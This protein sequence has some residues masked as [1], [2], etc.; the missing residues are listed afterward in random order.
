[1]KLT[2]AGLALV[3]AATS[4][5]ALA[6][7]QAPANAANAAAP[8]VKPSA[9]ASKA[10][11]DLQ[12]AVNA[13]DATSIPAKV[14]AANAVA[15]T[16]E[17]RYLIGELQLSGAVH[18]NDLA[19]ASQ[20]IDEIA[21]S[22][23]LPAPQVAKLYDAIGGS[24]YKAKQY[25]QAVAAYQHEIALDPQATDPQLM[26]SQ[27]RSDQGRPADALPALQRAIQ[28]GTAAG[29]K[30]EE[31][32]YKQAVALAYNAKLPSSVDL[33]RQ[34]VAAYPSETS[35]K[36][37][38]AVYR[39]IHGGSSPEIFDMLRLA[40]LTQGMHG[41]ADYESYAAQ[42]IEQGNFGEARTVMDAGINAGV[43]NAKDSRAAEILAA[44][45]GKVPTAADLAVA[46]KA[47]RIPNAYLRVGDRYYAA[48]NYTKAAELYREAQAKG[49]DGGLANLR[50]GEALARAGD[51]AGATAALNAVSGSYADLAKFW[52]VYVQQ[53][54]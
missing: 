14:A 13:K 44:L 5:T 6:Q 30:P 9:K 48:G 37:S 3:L 51:K 49:A 46:E 25:D 22:G 27:I 29:K 32:V 33:A 18:A 11:I 2:T 21:A 54:A 43:I 24:L 10:I 42:A 45:K 34:W 23:V 12:T 47:A 15:T 8:S 7:A 16:K 26:I 28:L 1:M 53:H 4:T 31:A 35:W 17:D 40:I 36:D 20:A 52:L 19:S 39:S 41:A 50:I 38:M